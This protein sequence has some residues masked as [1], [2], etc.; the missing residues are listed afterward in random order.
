MSGEVASLSVDTSIRVLDCFGLASVAHISNP[1]WIMFG[2]RC[3]RHR[4]TR[5]HFGFENVSTAD[6]RENIK[7]VCDVGKLT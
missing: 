1:F 4:F 3:C 2:P 7:L 5:C 6:T